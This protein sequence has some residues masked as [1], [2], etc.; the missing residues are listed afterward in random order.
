MLWGGGTP[1]LVSVAQC[2]AE[3]SQNCRIG[4]AGKISENPKPT[5]QCP[6]AVLSVL[7]LHRSG[8]PPGSPWVLL[9]CGSHHTSELLIP[10]PAL[11][12]ATG[13]VSGGTESLHVLL[14]GVGI[15]S[16][17]GKGKK[18]GKAMAGDTTTALREGCCRQCW[19]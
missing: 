9:C 8:T 7:H 11:S 16:L 2:G 13:W 10:P 17:Q 6:L 12:K 19:R 18:I 14:W 4:K 5:P 15:H 1:M 3:Q